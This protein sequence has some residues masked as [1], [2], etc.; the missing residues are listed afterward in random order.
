MDFFTKFSPFFQALLSFGVLIV[1]LGYCYEKFTSGRGKNKKEAS[2]QTQLN[3]TLIQGLQEQIKALDTLVERQRKEAKEDKERA[4]SEIM[5]LTGEV[6]RLN[7]VISEKDGKL[8]E[9]KEIFQG[10][11]P[12][13]EDT[14][15]AISQFMSGMTPF[16]EKIAKHFDSE[17]SQLP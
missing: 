5:K 17:H 14:L 1:G 6:G 12:Q 16:M 15:K 10:Y 9:Y 7:G 3:T 2:E 4:H 13:L 8:K 11:N